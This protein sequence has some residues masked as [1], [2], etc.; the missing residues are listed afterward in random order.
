MDN[1]VVATIQMTSSKQWQDN[2]NTAIDLIQQASNAGAQLVVLPEFFIR[3]SDPN[4]DNFFEIVEE[5]GIGKIQD[6]LK[7]SARQNN[8]YLVAGTIPIRSKVSGKYYNTTIVYGPNGDMLC[9]YKKV[10]LFSLYN[11][12][13]NIDESRL[14]E[15]GNDVTTFNIGQFS[16]GL[17]ICYDL[18][19]PELFRE[20][21]GVDS[22]II[23][24]AFTYYTGKAH[25]EVLL[26]ARA[27]ENQCYVIAS[28]QSGIHDNGRR[29]FG[30]SM[31]IDP[32]GMIKA[33]LEEGTGFVLGEINK[34]EIERIRSELPAL[35]HMKF[36]DEV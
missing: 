24:A 1:L 28:A 9:Y 11:Q 33:I 4:E 12:E 3:I 17:S 15:S 6:R 30:H 2:L 31:I 22:I 18:R 32:W 34:Q 14:F 23:P 27:I 5:I 16:F 19:F 10:H 26:R 36:M 8:I 20:M 25:W 7:N 35:Q 29:T 13:H 21:A